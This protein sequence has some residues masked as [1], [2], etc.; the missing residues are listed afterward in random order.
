MAFLDFGEYFRISTHTAAPFWHLHQYN[1]INIASN[2]KS[3]TT[4]SYFS[5]RFFWLSRG[6]IGRLLD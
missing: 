2:I 1:K 6:S 4:H 5:S 3:N